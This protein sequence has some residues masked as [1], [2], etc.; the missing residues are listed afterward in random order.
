MK[1]LFPLLILFLSLFAIRL[2][3]GIDIPLDG[4]W[5]LP[6]GAKITNGVMTITAP[7]TAPRLASRSIDASDYIGRSLIVHFEVKYSGVSEPKESHNGI[8]LMIHTKVGG[9]QFWRNCGK[10]TGSGD[11]QIITVKESIPWDTEWIALESGL[12]GSTGTLQ[13]RK[14]EIRDYRPEVLFREPPVALPE[15]FRCEYTE[16]VR[17]LPQM[18]GVMSPTKYRKEDIPDMAKWNINLLRWQL[19]PVP[20]GGYIPGIASQPLAENS[21]N[22]DTF[23]K[24]LEQELEV[25]DS[26]VKQ[27]RENGIMVIVDMHRIPGGTESKDEIQGEARL[28]DSEELTEEFIDSW[29][30]IARRYRNNPVIYGYDLMNEP[31]QRSLRKIDYL[32]LQYRTAQAIREIDQETPI[33]IAA[34]NWNGPRAF[35]YLH[36]LPLKNLIY[37]VHMYHPLRYTHQGVGGSWNRQTWPGVS[38]GKYWD[39][40]VMQQYLAPVRKFQEKYGARIVM[41]E[42]GVVRWAPNG[43]DY[44]RDLIG[45]AEEYRWDWCYHAFREWTGWSAELSDNRDDEKTVD[46]DNPRLKVLQNAFRKNIRPTFGGDTT[47]K[48][49]PIR[50]PVPDLNSER[51]K[52]QQNATLR[53][54]TLEGIPTLTVSLEKPGNSHLLLPLDHAALAGRKLVLS[55]EIAQKNITSKPKPWNGVKLMLIVTDAD[56]KKNYP[57]AFTISGSADWTRRCL[58]AEIPADVRMVELLLGLENVSGTV[59]FRNLRLEEA[60]PTADYSNTVITGW[61]DRDNAVYVP[62]E[63]MKFYFRILDAGRSVPGRVRI[64]FSGDDGSRRETECD[65]SPERPLEVTAALSAPG[66]MMVR[67]ALLSPQGAVVNRKD[68][69]GS[70]RP[71]EYGLAAG[72]EVEKIREGVPEPADFDAFWKKTRKELDAVPMTAPERKFFGKIGGCDVFDVKIPAPGPR[73]AIGYLSIPEGAKKGSLPIDLRFD[74]YAV[75]SINPEVSDK[76]IVFFVNA[77]GIENHR[78][79]DYYKKLAEGELYAYGFDDRENEKPD[80]CYFKSMIL[81]DLRALEYAKSLPEWDGKTIHISGG[82]QGAFQAAAVTALSPDATACRLTIPWFCDLGGIRDGRTRGWRPNWQPGLGYYDTVNFARRIKCP[83]LIYAGLSDWVCPPS[84][85]QILYNNLNVPKKMVMFQGWNHAPYFGYDRA[86]AKQLVQ[87]K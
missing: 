44:L 76:A 57:Q 73:P 5:K 8:K 64:L 84:G 56:G 18:R 30:K 24:A 68:D 13:I 22:N 23:A 37:N 60:I 38:R 66:F 12:Q 62:G 72:V 65:I 79:A 67:A 46:H 33:L 51:V 4:Q 2:T 7:D 71:V 78:E 69:R 48:T 81:R 50:F 42:F 77:H 26:V 34:N 86:R 80:T 43:A 53:V 61:T 39:K 36:P 14:V 29:R 6:A 58:A 25:L 10:Y 54:E 40:Q 1:K 87:E 41:S 27:C 47:G 9:K 83:V 85:V 3:A 31:N 82:S 15:G 45:L 28:F 52:S 63:P 75:H 74:G 17:N 16:R 11:W 35:S 20:R 21:G 32:T 59:K 19:R 49:A 70:M 55:A